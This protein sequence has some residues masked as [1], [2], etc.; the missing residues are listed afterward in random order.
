MRTARTNRRSTE[1]R[2]DDDGAP[3][4]GRR[5]LAAA[6]ITFGLVT[7]PVRLYP[8]AAVSGG[9]SFH[10]LH[11]KDNSRLKQQ[12]V[13]AK[14]GTVVP[15]SEMV[16]GYEIA[17]GRYVVMTDEEL[18]AL[19]AQASR[20]I[21]IAE[22]VPE[23]SLP[24]V[25]V[26]RSYYVGPDKGGEKAYGLLTAAMEEEQLLAIARYAARGKDY[27]VALRAREGRLVMHQ[28]FHQDEVREP[29]APPARAQ[30]SPAELQLAKQL[31]E[32]IAARRFDPSRYEDEVRKRIRQLIA[33]KAKGQEIEAP[34]AEPR[35]AEVIDLMA[36]LKAS[37][38]SRTKDVKATRSK[39]KPAR[40]KHSRPRRKAG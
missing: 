28:L 33:K 8:T 32:S 34:E 25:Y 36:A 4:R 30:A 2:S 16:K 3:A 7:V 37:L 14:E 6:T 26:E 27:L 20:G 38:A 9:L 31:I 11:A 5:P 40:A 21:E 29:V 19:D 15:R 1:S 35:K 22:F 12:Y 39:G 23:D 10:L 18:R 17:K 13:C 24:I